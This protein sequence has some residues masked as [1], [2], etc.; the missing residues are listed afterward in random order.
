MEFIDCQLFKA[1]DAQMKKELTISE[2]IGERSIKL[3]LNETKLDYS[4]SKFDIV[5]EIYDGY[6]L[7]LEKIDTFKGLSGKV[8]FEPLVRK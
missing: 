6:S 2:L 7:Y 1:L 8:S 3:V 4:P 5:N